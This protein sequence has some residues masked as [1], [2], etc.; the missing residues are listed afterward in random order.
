MI[1]DPEIQFGG[2][3]GMQ[4]GKDYSWWG[5]GNED[6]DSKILLGRA[7]KEISNKFNYWG[8]GD[9][10]MNLNPAPVVNDGQVNKKKKNWQSYYMVMIS[11]QKVGSLNKRGL[12]LSCDVWLDPDFKVKYPCFPT[13][14]ILFKWSR[15]LVT[16]LF[17]SNNTTYHCD[18]NNVTYLLWHHNGCLL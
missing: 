15:L 13:A 3:G 14:W 4:C 2:G 9:K 7:G 16:W 5:G 8:G 12:T 18:V 6:I 10:G 11:S 17:G 1:G